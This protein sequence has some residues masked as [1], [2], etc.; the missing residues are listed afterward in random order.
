MAGDVKLM[1]LMMNKRKEVKACL[2][3]YALHAR[4]VAGQGGAA[5]TDYLAPAS[6]A[7]VPLFQYL[8]KGSREAAERSGSREKKWSSW[9]KA[10]SEDASG[11]SPEA[12]VFRETAESH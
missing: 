3:R 1:L 5:A 10:L 2:C 11:S 8:H 6:S 9:K 7:A 4:P 12:A